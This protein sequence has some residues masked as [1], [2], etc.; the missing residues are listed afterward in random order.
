[1]TEQRDEDVRIFSNDG[2]A[3]KFDADK[4][5][6]DLF[7]PEALIEIGKV[8]GHGAIKYGEHN[9]RGGMKWGRLFAA[10]QRHLQAWL[11]GEDIDPDSGLPHLAHAGC[12][13]AFLI[14]YQ[15]SGIGADDRW[16][17]KDPDAA[18]TRRQAEDF[19]E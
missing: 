18:W 15:K 17:R 2:G 6:L 8:L 9:W 4:I 16:K 1:M 14:A 7:P 10:A 11:S 19:A 13:I 5:P 3:R 12:C